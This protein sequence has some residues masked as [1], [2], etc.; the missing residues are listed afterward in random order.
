LLWFI[1]NRDAEKLH[2][3]IARNL[4]RFCAYDTFC[5]IRS[6]VG[7]GVDKIYLD[8]GILNDNQI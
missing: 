4:T 6:S 1:L 2:Y 8:S 7:I 5:K 3:V